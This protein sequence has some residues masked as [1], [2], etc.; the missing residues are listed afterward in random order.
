MKWENLIHNM[1]TKLKNLF[2]NR[3]PQHNFSPIV[4]Y[5]NLILRGNKVVEFT[6][7]L[8]DLKDKDTIYVPSKNSSKVHIEN[9]EVLAVINVHDIN[10]PF[11]AVKSK[12]RNFV[13]KL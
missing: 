2:K 9:C 4:L 12:I 10:A 8:K 6:N 3:K 11:K 5:H 1:L 13:K 7:E